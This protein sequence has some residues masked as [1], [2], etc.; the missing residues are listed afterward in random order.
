[1]V[2]L[3][4]FLL[5]ETATDFSMFLNLP[6]VSGKS[7]DGPF[8]GFIRSEVNCRI[9]IASPFRIVIRFCLSSLIWEYSDAAAVPNARAV[10]E[11]FRAPPRGPRPFTCGL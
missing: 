11:T 2:F 9:I 3:S 10:Q 7:A 5:G 8:C 1:M 6:T 4:W